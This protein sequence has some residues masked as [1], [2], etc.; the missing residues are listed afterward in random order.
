MMNV[1]EK[2][3]DQTRA[4]FILHPSAFCLVRG[5]AL[6]A[7]LALALAAAPGCAKKESRYPADYARYQRIDKAVEALR[8]TYV[9]KDESAFHGLLL[10]SDRMDRLESQVAQDFQKYKEITL[11]L[12]IERIV[13]DGEQVDVF[14]HWQGL[15]KDQGDLEQRERGHGMLR[16]MGV[17]SIFLAGTDG[18]V[19]F[20]VS[21]RRT[22]TPPAA[23]Q[24]APK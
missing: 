24:G 11:D 10:P 23:P 16:L 6:C 12:S 9:K 20:G 21:A 4:P 7:A 8:T 15:W 19:P 13:V 1:G 17:Q 5:L 2:R 18:D 14:V 3:F 22:E